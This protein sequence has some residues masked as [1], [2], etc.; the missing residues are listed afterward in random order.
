V[1]DA[2]GEAVD[3]TDASPLQIQSSLD[4]LHGMVAN[5]DTAQQQQQMRAQLEH[6]AAAISN[7]ATKHDDT[8]RILVAL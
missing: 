6:Q 5:I 4:L 2:M 8:A 1:L 3:Q 7:G